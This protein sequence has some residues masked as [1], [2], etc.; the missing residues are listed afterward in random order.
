VLPPES[1]LYVC[2]RAAAFRARSVSPKGGEGLLVQGG[3]QGHLS[4]LGETLTLLDAAGAVNNTTTYEGQ[5]SDVQRYLVV[6]E[7]HYHPA[8]DGLAEFVELLNISPSVTLDLRGVRITQ[9]VDFDFADSAITSLPP[10]GRVLIVRDLA[11]FTAAYGSHLPVAGVF[12]NDTA[13]S[14]S[15][16]VI[17]LEEALQGT[18]REFAYDDAAPWPVEADAGWSLVLIAPETNPDHTLAANW[19]ASA[20]PGGSPGRPDDARFP[21]DPLGDADGNGER[22]LIDYVLGNAPGVSS[23]LP[24]LTAVA[25]QGSEPAVLRLSYAVSLTATSADVGVSFSTDLTTWQDATPHLELVS[26]ESL[27]DG[28]EQVTWRVRPPLRDEPRVFL[29]LRAVVR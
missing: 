13:L 23:R 2:P 19:R 5:P 29:R 25:G 26:T 20:R 9:G 14:N 24:T 17:K 11:A 7:L 16:E 21:A 8:G 10:G 15:G 22:D 1:A 12:R 4:S 27:S 6:S 28:R 18:I 3:Y